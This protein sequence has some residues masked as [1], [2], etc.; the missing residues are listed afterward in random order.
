[1]SFYF[2]VVTRETPHHSFV[3]YR[4]TG[5]PTTITVI[6]VT[7]VPSTSITSSTS[8]AISSTVA[9]ANITSTS[10]ASG[11]TGEA[12]QPVVVKSHRD[13]GIGIGVGVGCGSLAV[14]LVVIATYFLRKRRRK[15]GDTDIN[16]TPTD[17]SETEK[18][19]P[20]DAS[21]PKVEENSVSLYELPAQQPASHR[22][23]DTISE[24]P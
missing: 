17:L 3:A 12:T 2:K 24:L 14:A 13:R 10:P 16:F 8:S 22:R 5:S 11:A 21:Q 1:M 20:N 9:T 6:G 19:M 18:N 4:A 7:S 15:S 23:T